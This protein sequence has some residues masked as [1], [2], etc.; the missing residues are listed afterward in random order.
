MRSSTQILMMSTFLA[1]SSCTALRASAVVV[2]QYGAV[3]RPGSGAVMP[4]PAV[5]NLA[6]PGIVCARTWNEA[7]VVSRPRLRAAPIPKYAR[8]RRSSIS[9]WRVWLRWV[10]VSMIAGITVLPARFT[11]VAPAGTRTSAALPTCTKRAPFTTNDAFSIGVRPSP[12][13]T[14]APSKT[15]TPVAGACPRAVTDAAATATRTSRFTTPSLLLFVGVRGLRRLRLTLRLQRLVLLVVE[16][17]DVHPGVRHFVDRAVAEAHPLIRIRV[18]L[19]RLR[20]VV[21]GRHVDDRALR[22]QRR[23]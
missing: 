4:R 20:V 8:R 19:I 6:R 23:G 16:V 11:R 15:A 3:V 22:Q 7:S 9:I 1:A 2:T 21:P 5:K 18:V 13:M 12:T 14:R 17:R 10:C